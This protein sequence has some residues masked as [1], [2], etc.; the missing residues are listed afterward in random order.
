MAI[1]AHTLRELGGAPEA[2]RKNLLDVPVEFQVILEDS[3]EAAELADAYLRRGVL[4][5][6]SRADA[7]HVAL[8]T[9]GRVDVLAS[10]NFKH[11]VNLSR[12]RLFHSVNI[13]LGFNE[14][15]IRSPRE[16]LRYEE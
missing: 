2:V 4:S 6:G 9:I 13:E 14:I 3:P 12:I 1:S 5:P 8:A 7:L 10:W 15:E 11:P 16:L